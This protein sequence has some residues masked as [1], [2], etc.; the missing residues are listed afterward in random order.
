[1]YGE[2]LVGSLVGY[3]IENSRVLYK[4]LQKR[5]YKLRYI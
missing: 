3:M 2:I 1:M 5:F 4:R